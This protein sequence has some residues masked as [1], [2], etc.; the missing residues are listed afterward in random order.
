MS[1]VLANPVTLKW[2]LVTIIKVTVTKAPDK[3]TEHQQARLHNV[4]ISS[5]SVQQV[6]VSHIEAVRTFEM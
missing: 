5:H 3:V 1:P 4:R 2:S 6:T